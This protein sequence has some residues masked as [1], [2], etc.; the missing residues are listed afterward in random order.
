MPISN[1]EQEYSYDNGFRPKD[2]EY[3]DNYQFYHRTFWFNFLRNIILTL[4]VPLCSIYT[5]IRF[6]IKVVGKENRKQAKKLMKNEGCLLICNHITPTDA[7]SIIC[8][9]YPQK[10]FV[11]SLK[12]NMGFGIISKVM[13]MGGIVPIPTTLK[14]MREFDKQTVEALNDKQSILF[15]AEGSLILFSG[16]IRPFQRG[17]FKYAQMANKKIIPLCITFHK[18]NKRK[19]GKHPLLRLNYLPAYEIEKTDNPR[20]NLFKATQDLEKIVGEY[21][22]LNSDDEWLDEEGLAL[23]KAL[24]EK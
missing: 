11:P 8:N 17:A 1:Q 10:I 24:L 15:M 3:P 16:H 5:K 21:F 14:K 22:V 9:L 19:K 7:V 18:K 13:R 6:R 20:E 23:K 12:T 2:W 4:F